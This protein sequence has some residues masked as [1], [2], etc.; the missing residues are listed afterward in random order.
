[1]RADVLSRLFRS[2][3]RLMSLPFIVVVCAVLRVLFAGREIRIVV[4]DPRLFGH[5]S[6][7]PEVFWDDWQSDVERGSRHIWFCCLGKKSS[8]SNAKLWQLTKDKF[9]TLPSWFVTSVAHWKRSFNFSQLVLLDASIY[10]LGFL[11]RRETTL[12]RPDTML[13]RRREIL[14]RLAEPER[15]YV[16][17]TIRE[18]D[19]ASQVNEL[20]NRQIS[21][22][23]PAMNA[24]VERGFNVIRLT[25]STKDPLAGELKHVLDWQVLVDGRP[26]DELAVVSGAS[27]VVSTTTGG[28]CLALAYRRP[29]LYLDSARFCL[30]FLGTELATFQMPRFVDS[31]TGSSL[32][33]EQLLERDLGWVGEQQSF[34]KSS[35]T[36]VNS[37]PQEIHNVVI[38]YHDTGAW[39]GGYAA[40]ADESAWRELLMMRHGE[41][42]TR[43]HGPVRALM[44]PASKHAML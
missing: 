31:T 12:P 40:D 14:S 10:R 35:V 24:L 38:Q 44:H 29:V 7:E 32:S 41:Q 4:M 21:D 6:L 43:R 2:V 11:V 8:A 33:L 19:R 36:V 22:L 17:F 30:I 5:Q 15:P 3:V 23:V 39:R 42:V 20:R 16:V 34:A 26:G 25:S 37:D 27:F 9:P 13:L 18:F 28:D 1:M